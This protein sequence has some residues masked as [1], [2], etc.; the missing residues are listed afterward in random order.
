M[1]RL[2]LINTEW[3]CYNGFIFK[4]LEVESYKPNLDSA[5]FGLNF[6]RRF[7][8]IDLFFFNFKVFDRNENRNRN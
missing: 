3:N 8:Y 7:L 2:N 6:S 4:I 1:N 5:L